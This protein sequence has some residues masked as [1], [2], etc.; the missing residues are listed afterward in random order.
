M[1]LKMLAFEIIWGWIILSCTAGPLFAW[2]FF[3]PVRREDEIRR[4]GRSKTPYKGPFHLL[5]VS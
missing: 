2:A 5:Q 4:H 3:F 1:E